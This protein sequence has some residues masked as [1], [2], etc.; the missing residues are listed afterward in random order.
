VKNLSFFRGIVYTLFFLSLSLNYFLW[1]KLNQAQ[2]GILVTE[3]LDGDT[4]LLEQDVRLRLRQIDAPETKFCG[5]Q[6]AKDK[7]S[8]LVKGKKV[9]I[10]EEIIDQR[11]RPMVLLYQGGTFINLEMI[12]SGWVRYHSDQTSQTKIL[13]SAFADVKKEGKG[14]FSS[15]CYQRENPQN[16]SCR[17]KGNIDKNSG[18]RKYYYPGCAQY[19]FTIVEKDIGENWF[20]TQEAAVKAGFSKAETCPSNPPY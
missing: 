16:P 6:E 13:Q 1:Q 2:P 18:A 3:V 12:K 20:C 15:A 4:V 9:V 7:L 8:A 5:G 19:E 14:I 10:R 11:G 17:I